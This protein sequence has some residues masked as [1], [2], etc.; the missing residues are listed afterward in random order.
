MVVEL[1]SRRAPPEPKH[2]DLEGGDLV[3]ER[4]EEHQ[5]CQPVVLAAGGQEDGFVAQTQ[6]CQGNDRRH[7]Q[8]GIDQTDIA[9]RSDRPA[10]AGRQQRPD[11]GGQ[12][13]RVE[14][15]VND[16]AGITFGERNLVRPRREPNC[17]G[18]QPIQEAADR[19]PEPRGKRAGPAAQAQDLKQQ[20]EDDHLLVHDRLRPP[21]PDMT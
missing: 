7:H 21:H 8:N 20:S 14:S 5:Q 19:R 9:A 15:D 16:S 10:M 3:G 12:D 6:Q 18:P 13:Y 17:L 2:D 4:E 11:A 1:G